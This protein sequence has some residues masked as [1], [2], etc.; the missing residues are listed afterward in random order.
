MNPRA[1]IVQ[2]L[3]NTALSQREIAR[4]VGRSQ[5]SVCRWFNG[6]TLPDADSLQRIVAAYPQ[7]APYAIDAVIPH[8][9]ES[10]SYSSG[11]Q[12]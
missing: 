11:G 2:E 10:D 12:Q 4:R 5:V 1:R 9:T 7:L 8:R 6:R 3:K